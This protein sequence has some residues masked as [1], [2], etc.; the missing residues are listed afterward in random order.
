V[1]ASAL[2]VS[3][4]PPPLNFGISGNQLQFNWPA[5][6]LGWRLQMQTNSIDMGIGTNWVDVAGSTTTNQIIIPMD[7]A[8]GS[9]FFR[10]IYP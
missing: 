3:Q 9:V 10:L 4:T 5:D 1:E 7:P 8:N 2:P 6:H